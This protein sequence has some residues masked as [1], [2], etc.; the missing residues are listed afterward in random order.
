M[1][2][3]V[4]NM[5]INTF[6]EVKKTTYEIP[7]PLYLDESDDYQYQFKMIKF[8]NNGESRK[9]VLLSCKK[10]T[11]EIFIDTQLYT[12][13]LLYETWIENEWLPYQCNKN[14]FNKNYKF[15]INMLRDDVYD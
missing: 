3:R 4:I 12:N 14:V 1:N 13:D 5:I 8:Y 7:N 6:R 11:F 9:E 15:I 10:E 2:L